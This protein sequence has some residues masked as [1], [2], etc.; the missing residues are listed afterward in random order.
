[1]GVTGVFDDCLGL[2]FEAW[3]ARAL[4]P[5][6]VRAE[7]GLDAEFRDVSDLAMV[8]HVEVYSSRFVGLPKDRL[9]IFIRMLN[10]E[11]VYA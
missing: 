11:V 7:V 8:V 1:L 10:E 6:D 9:F 3:P 5:G 4:V 2:L